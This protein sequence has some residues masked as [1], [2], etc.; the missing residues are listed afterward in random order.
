[1][2]ENGAPPA[3]PDPVEQLLQIMARLRD[4]DSGC[5]WDIE[6]TYATIAPHTIEEA[7]EVADAIER[8]DMEALR[9]E[10]GDLL[11]Q[12]VFHSRMAE[13][14][15]LFDFRSVAKQCSDKLLRRHPHVFGDQKID[16]AEEQTAHWEQLKA[17]ERA[18]QAAARGGT[19][20]PSVLD[21]LTVAL[22]AMTRAY[23][24]Q[25]RAARV[26]FDWTEAKDILGKIEEELA[27]VRAEFEAAERH[28]ERLR[29]EIGDLLFT[30]VNLARKSHVDPET[31]LRH[32]NMKFERRFRHVERALQAR[33]RT[34]EA[35]TLAEME[36]LWQDAKKDEHGDQR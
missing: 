33:G 8:G 2:T 26:G 24:L 13:E 29:D 34:A 3:H 18:A 15:G 35:A 6:Q 9:D 14:E 32:T 5:P 28:P 4:P 19:G 22:P 10:L 17:Q 27:E 1:M 25:S 12:V 31:A 30:V 11:L 20:Q 21:N 36:A 7:Y 16:S 23:K